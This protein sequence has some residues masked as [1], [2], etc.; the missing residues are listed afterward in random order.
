VI[1]GVIGTAWEDVMELMQEY[2]RDALTIMDECGRHNRES[3]SI[4][5]LWNKDWEKLRYLIHAAFQLTLESDEPDPA[6]AEYNHIREQA[7][8]PP[9]GG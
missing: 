6:Y 7:G 4:T 3:N 8:L 9:L 2:L 5:I 1:I